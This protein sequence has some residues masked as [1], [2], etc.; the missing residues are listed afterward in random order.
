MEDLYSDIKS[1]LENIDGFNPD[2]LLKLI[3]ELTERRK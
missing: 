3:D 1:E 2:L